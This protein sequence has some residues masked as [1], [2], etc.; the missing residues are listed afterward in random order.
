M[1]HTAE[2]SRGNAA[3]LQSL[4]DFL[5]SHEI[6]AWFRLTKKGLFIEENALSKL[7]EAYRQWLTKAAGNTEPRSLEKCRKHFF[8]NDEP[9][10]YY[11][12]DGNK[13]L[14]GFL[15]AEEITNPRQFRIPDYHA[16]LLDTLNSLHPRDPFLASLDKVKGRMSPREGFVLELTTSARKYE[17]S[18]EALRD[19][20]AVLRGS[21]R[22]LSR[23]PEATKALRYCIAPLRQILE[24]SHE[25]PAGQQL[26][27]P[28]K[29]RQK[30]DLIFLRGHGIS[31]A[32]KEQRKLAACFST[33]GRNL[34]RFLRR[35]IQELSQLQGAQ[36]PVRGMQLDS[37]KKHCIAKT[38]S[39]NISFHIQLRAFILFLQQIEKNQ[40]TRKKLPR[41]YGVKDVL[42][43]FA[44]VFRNSKPLDLQ[45]VARVLGRRRDAAARYRRTG[46]W[47]F[48]V[49]DKNV[50]QACLS[51]REKPRSP[52]A[53]SAAAN[54]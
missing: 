13:C 40:K 44:T 47:L 33:K 22:L 32:L 16:N 23:F 4:P 43:R 11:V 52:T 21:P 24:Q 15:A 35:E 54:S 30:T 17:V 8:G 41:L 26:L 31:F 50:V 5:P 34:S 45:S 39:E 42:E 9:P 12:L 2:S 27:I 37:P 29:L 7:Y 51:F 18:E 53:E 48:V 28:E 25:L 49:H 20:A 1:S 14:P 36:P 10:L 6:Q 19:F 3:F 38:W 46:N